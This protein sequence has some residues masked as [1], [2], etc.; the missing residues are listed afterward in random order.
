MQLERTKEKTYEE[1]LFPEARAQDTSIPELVMKQSQYL[2]KLPFSAV[3]VVV[4]I[5]VFDQAEAAFLYRS[6][7]RQRCR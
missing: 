1:N 5:D 4:P 2:L 7:L 6:R 3:F